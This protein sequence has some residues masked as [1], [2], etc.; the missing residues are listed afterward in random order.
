[1]ISATK[2]I[3]PGKRIECGVVRKS[4]HPHPP[5]PETPRISLGIDLGTEQYGEV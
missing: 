2:K 5:G 3:K 1:M 4:P